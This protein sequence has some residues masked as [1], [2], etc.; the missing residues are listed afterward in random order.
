[1]VDFIEEY[2]TG[3]L[4]AIR[5]TGK[6]DNKDLDVLLPHIEQRMKQYDTIRFYWEMA[7]FEG[8]DVVSFLRDRFFELKHFNQFKKIALVGEKGWEEKMAAVMD[9]F[10]PARL[11]YFDLSARAEALQ[12]VRMD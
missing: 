4:I 8:W 1:M 3:D 9:K 5:T 7:S 2:S 10:T 11:K 6:I 12:W